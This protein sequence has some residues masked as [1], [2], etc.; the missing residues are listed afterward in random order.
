MSVKGKGAKRKGSRAEI[1]FRNMLR[2]IYPVEDHKNV[3]RVP[4]SGAGAMKCDVQDNNDPMMAYE[5]K[6]QEKLCLPEWWRQAKSQA[7][8]VRTPVLVVTQSFRPF[9]IIMHKKDF[10]G[11]LENSIYKGHETTEILTSTRNFMDRLAEL[12]NHCMAEFLLDDDTVVA[13]TS[14]FYLEIKEDL[15]TS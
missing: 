14:R 11:L 15:L 6:N 13:V 4:L 2:S 7:G 12:D 3:F 10:L 5:V 1:Q 9:Y 8:R